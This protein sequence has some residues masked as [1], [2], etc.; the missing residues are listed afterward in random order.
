MNKIT[1]A[2]FGVAFSIAMLSAG[3]S[4][5]KADVSIYANNGDYYSE[6]GP[7]QYWHTTSNE[8]YCGHIGSCSPAYMKWTYGGDPMSNYAIWDNPDNNWMWA[9]HDVFV[10]RVNA[11]TVRAPYCIMWGGANEYNFTVDQNSYYDSWVR[12][13]PAQYDLRSTDLSDVTYEN[14]TRRVG[15]DEIKIS[16]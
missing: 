13:A 2:L 15:F 4:A 9:D 11:T 3:A 10:P 6:Y 14:F 12:G 8:G 1:K 16:I 5:A 7:S